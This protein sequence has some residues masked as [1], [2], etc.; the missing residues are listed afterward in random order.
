MGQAAWIY[1]K[2]HAWTDNDGDPEDALTRD[3]MLDNI[4]LYWLTGT[5]ASSA[6][7]YLENAGA[8]PNAGVV[9]IPVG[10]SNFPR[11]IFPAPRSW[12]ERVYPN[13]VYWN[14]LDRGGHFAAFEEPE[15]FTQELRDA[16][17]RCDDGDGRRAHCSP[18]RPSAGWTSKLEHLAD[19]LS[20]AGRETR[21]IDDAAHDRIARGMAGRA[22]GSISGRE[23]AHPAAR[24]ATPRGASCHGSRSRRS[25][26]STRR[27][28][29]RRSPTCSTAAAS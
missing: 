8:N 18:R 17:G 10:C 29:R 2:F 9:E 12:A 19:R 25:T 16:F 26:S 3:E 22:Q 1:E 7:M 23:G 11:E 15:L 24:P 13:L 21:E 27:R 28:A 5:A 20:A 6:R 4:T 14:E